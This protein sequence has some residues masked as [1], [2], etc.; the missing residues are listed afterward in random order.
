ML[1]PV[2][3]QHGAGLVDLGPRRGERC[4]L[5]LLL[6]EA[7]RGVLTMD[8]LQNLLWDDDPPGN[9]QRTVHTY[10]ARLRA[11]LRPHGVRIITSSNGYRVDL[12]AAQVDAHRF[13]AAITRARAAAAPGVRARILAEALDLW[14]GP[15]LADVAGDYLRARIGA[16]LEEHRFAAIELLAQADLDCGRHH[17]VLTDL[18]HVL[19]EHP[20]RERL[21]E[22]LMLAYYRAGRQ[23]E[24][25]SAYRRVWQTLDTE[26]GV[27]P[28]PGLR[29]LHGRI[30]ANDPSLTT[31]TDAAAANVP[32]FLPR[33]VPDFTGREADLRRLDAIA[34]ESG[35]AAGAALITTISGTPGVGKTALAIHWGH[36]SVH[37]FPDG[38]LYVNLR[39]FDT[40][41]PLHPIDALA[42]LLRALGQPSDKISVDVDEASGQY[43]SLLADRRMLVLLDNAATIDQVRPLLPGGTGSFALITSRNRLSGLLARDGVRRLDL[44]MLSAA[45]AYQLLVRILGAE[46]VA[47]EPDAATDLA[48]ACA[49]LPLAL[50]IAAANLADQP[51]QP[52]AQYVSLLR[53]GDR[54]A[55]LAIDGDLDSTIRAAFDQSYARLSHGAARL[56]RLLGVAP[57]PDV[58]AEAAAA[59]AAVPTETAEVLLRQLT[60]AHLVQNPLEGRY[61]LHDLLR[62][63]A[64]SQADPGA[65]DARRLLIEWY[66]VRADAA[67]RQMMPNLPLPP[68]PQTA[69]DGH[70][71]T[72]AD[73]FT[74]EAANL[75]ACV[76]DAHD[77]GL[78]HHCCA[79][80]DRMRAHFHLSRDMVGWRPVAEHAQSAAPAIADPFLAGAEGSAAEL[81][82][83][84]YY[85]GLG[86][87]DAAKAHSGR[88]IDLAEAVGWADGHAAALANLGVIHL[89]SSEH[90]RSAEYSRRA[91]DAH[92]LAGNGAGQAQALGNLGFVALTLGNLGEAEQCFREAVAL[93]RT[94]G[95]RSSEGLALANLGDTL[96]Y[97]GR[98]D[99]AIEV[100]TRALSVLRETGGKVAEAVAQINLAYAQ[101]ESG[102]SDAALANA[103][104]ALDLV[105]ETGDPNAEANVLN[106]LAAVHAARGEHDAAVSL[107][108]TAL[109]LCVS[110]G[111]RDPELDAH[112]GLTHALLGTGHPAAAHTHATIALGLARDLDI[113]ISH[114]YAAAALAAAKLHLGDR[115]G[116]RSLALEARAHHLETGVTSG[117]RAAEALLARL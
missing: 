19:D 64:R 52:I 39:G 90:A 16:G 106:R 11:R 67:A 103:T 37:R 41:R 111:G 59:L 81:S 69:P 76:R 89:W 21:T 20:T 100:L 14:R 72:T 38:Q 107:F 13:T 2:E 84:F 48:A 108:Q 22:L 75:A 94:A 66:L 105:R 33:T 91:L 87:Y 30:L 40:G 114:G 62:L 83:A 3:V 115:D 68:M 7:G 4:L 73:W 28:G 8:R 57:G 51:D 47:A 42:L 70:I 35:D 54:L 80:A 102:Q 17:K 117:V 32:R 29:D 31:R 36:R 104:A 109:D 86:R 26:L 10:V 23:G 82:L 92:R 49:H 15:P 24:A 88:A 12:D 65:P 60:A 99:E 43:R 78:P 53:G 79:L 74:D 77:H 34:D 93:H 101:C 113:R 25:L 55:A 18:A 112:V 96:R 44:P 71:T 97:A 58:T 98:C 46:R 110:I 61:S 45:D 27:E 50:R 1:G 56:F 95:A 6:L 5:G 85:R 63:Y 9:A 116:A